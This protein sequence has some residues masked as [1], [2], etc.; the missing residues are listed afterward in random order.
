MAAGNLFFLG[1]CTGSLTFISH[2][3][4]KD[5]Q[6]EIDSNSYGLRKGGKKNHRI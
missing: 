2:V 1:N 5:M 4:G 3:V 6:D